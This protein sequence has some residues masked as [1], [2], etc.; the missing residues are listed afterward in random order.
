MHSIHKKDF[1]IRHWISESDLAITSRR[2]VIEADE[3]R[4]YLNFSGYVDT[5]GV[6]KVFF[7][8]NPDEASGQYDYLWL[9]SGTYAKLETKDGFVFNFRSERENVFKGRLVF[10]LLYNASSFFCTLNVVIRS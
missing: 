4:E 8:K 10:E 7:D 5:G 6:L 1:I 3:G 9:N 2:F